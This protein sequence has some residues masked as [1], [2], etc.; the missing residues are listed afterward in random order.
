MLLFSGSRSA[1]EPIS[2]LGVR[3]RRG[4]EGRKTCCVR[5]CSPGSQ[6]IE[7]RSNPRMKGQRG[8]V[9]AVSLQSN[10]GRL[11]GGNPTSALRPAP[12]ASPACGRT[13]RCHGSNR[14]RIPASPKPALRSPAAGPSGR[15]KKPFVRPGDCLLPSR[16]A[17]TS[18]NRPERWC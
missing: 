16:P 15:R 6:T 7:S 4:L 2:Q 13:A 17:G 10:T 8:K 5:G 11:R 14:S 12:A 9:L 18:R 1:W 3:G